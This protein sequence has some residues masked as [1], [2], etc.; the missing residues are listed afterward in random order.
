MGT[1]SAPPPAPVGCTHGVTYQGYC[2]DT[3]AIWCDPVTGQTIAWNCAQDG[4]TCQENG[5]ADGAYCCG[6]PAM[7]TTD[8]MATPPDP[9]ADCSAL[10]Y[11]GAC[12]GDTA[13]W[14]DNGQ[15]YR[16]DCAASGKSCMVDTCASGAYCC[17]APV[18][19]P[20]LTTPPPD[21]LDPCLAAGLDCSVIGGTCQ[22]DICTSGWSCCP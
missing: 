7:S 16:V 19:A 4:Y 13:T 9:T 14:C 3:T 1:G 5:C 15:I 8:D 18:A 12:D 10:G 6:T 21:L 2:A 22:L 20:D 11:S 17:D